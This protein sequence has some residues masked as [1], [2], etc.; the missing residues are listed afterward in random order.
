[1]SGA[2]AALQAAALA[3]VAPLAGLSGAYEGPPVQA[4]YPYALVE[5]GPETDWG[6]K[7]GAGSE[8]RLAVSVRDA[9]ATPR[10]LYALLDA[11][12]SAIEAGLAVEG[13]QVVTLAWERT[14]TAREGKPAVG[15]DAVWAG[16]VEF[17]ARLLGAP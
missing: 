6:H 12:R 2:A 10:R 1:V 16:A 3:R 15:A 5:A 8:V 7:S 11:A 14:R 17:R 13:W 9:G 4:A